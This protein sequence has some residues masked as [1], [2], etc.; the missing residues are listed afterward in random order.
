M[1]DNQSQD[2]D[3]Q[4]EKFNSEGIMIGII[5]SLELDV[6]QVECRITRSNE[7]YFHSRIVQ[8]HIIRHQIQVPRRISK[9][10]QDLRFPTDP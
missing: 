1:V 10:K 6:H 3:R 8:T 2:G 4:Q 7:E 9:C 5:S